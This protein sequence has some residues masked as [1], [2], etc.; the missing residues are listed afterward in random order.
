MN[1]FDQQLKNISSNKIYAAL[2]DMQFGDSLR[3]TGEKK[4]I[5]T[6]IGIM[7]PN[8]LQTG[9]V[10]SFHINKTGKLIFQQRLFDSFPR[11]VQTL[12]I[13]I[14]YTHKNDFLVAGFGNKEGGLFLMKSEGDGGFSKKMIRALPGA[15]KTYIEDINNDGLPDIQALMSRLIVSLI[16]PNQQAKADWKQSR[17]KKTE[18]LLLRNSSNKK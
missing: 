7:N 12:S 13:D 15:I 18:I 3:S 9:T 11:P 8:D 1:I 4:G 16:P 17:G 2:V 5:M 14:D 10:D 6:N